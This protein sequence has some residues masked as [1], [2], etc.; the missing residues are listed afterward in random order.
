[1]RRFGLILHLAWYNGDHAVPKLP[2]QKFGDSHS[3][4]ERT[5]N[6][7]IGKEEVQI[8]DSATWNVWSSS[9]WFSVVFVGN[10]TDTKKVAGYIILCLST[11][12]QMGLGKQAISMG[13]D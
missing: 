8:L 7:V 12:F 10:P 4:N 9:N 11:V 3:L 5:D 13:L 2:F 1:M 6:L